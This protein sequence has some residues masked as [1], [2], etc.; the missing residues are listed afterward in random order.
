MNISK[1]STNCHTES[2]TEQKQSTMFCSTSVSQLSLIT[3]Q[4]MTF[5]SCR[6]KN[7]IFSFDLGRRILLF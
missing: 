4:N 1:M 3:V 5:T 6:F 2:R 7:N